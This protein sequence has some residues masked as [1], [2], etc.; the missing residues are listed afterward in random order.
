MKTAETDP[1]W[2]GLAALDA[3]TRL[4]Q[5]LVRA[6]G[7]RAG[8]EAA[9]L[10]QS[11]LTR[12]WDDPSSAEILI[13]RSYWA[14][15][16]SADDT[17]DQIELQGAILLR[18]G[19]VSSIQPEGAPAA[20]LAQALQQRQIS[21]WS[22]L[23]SSMRDSQVL[24]SGLLGI[25]VLGAATLVTLEAVLFSGA[26]SVGARL[27]LL[28]QRLGGALALIILVALLLAFESGIAAAAARLGRRLEIRLRAQ[29]LASMLSLPPGYLGSRPISDLAE[30]LHAAYRIRT[31]P[32]DGFRIIQV[33]AQILITGAAI[34]WLGAPIGLALASAF[35]AIAAPL[36]VWPL[37]FEQD[38]RV[39]THTGAL[40]RFYFETLAG[41]VT[42]RAHASSQAIRR[43]Q[44]SLLVDWVHASRGRLGTVL[45]MDFIQGIT[46][47]GL[48][49]WIMLGQAQGPAPV[50]QFLLL[51]Y[52]TLTLPLLGEELSVLVRRLPNHRSITQRLI[53]PIRSSEPEPSLPAELPPGAIGSPASLE[54]QGVALHFSEVC[55]T[56]GGH[57][58]LEDVSL[59]IAAGEHV[60]ILGVSGAGKSTL[61]G[62]VLGTMEPSGGELRADEQPL[63]GHCLT[64]L[65]AET[66][67]IDPS[68]QLWNR[69]LLDNLLF[70]AAPGADDRVGDAIRDSTLQSV[71]ARLPRGLQDSVGEGG[72][73]L[74]GGEGQK[75]RIARAMLRDGV[76]LAVLDEPF[77]GLDASQRVLLLEQ[78]RSRW[79]G[80]TM[81]VVTHDVS[82]T[83]TFDR[84]LVLADGK[85]VEEGRP[86][87]LRTRA[88]SLYSSM[89][90]D[91]ARAS[92]A[93][94][95][96]T[97]WTRW[98]MERGK[99][100]CE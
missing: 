18:V 71:L 67:W 12:A 80:A 52:W 4:V 98:C 77:R 99:L 26:I 54:A 79:R 95:A 29:F 62:L 93:T 68:V 34:V 32:R 49:I 17:S 70:G 44:E 15:R 82:A 42:V 59:S 23:V 38:M 37:L 78:C 89:L 64:R 40:S 3:G 97:E 43:E 6:R 27:G 57:R 2:F 14:A 74:S 24:R 9:R 48:A 81:L 85:L 94:W 47:F 21:P 41:L 19:G 45:L 46:G 92:E 39:R 31:F 11:Q 73:S 25:A 72:G 1:T 20:S 36:V 66:A 10:L 87:E 91:G 76:R 96:S 30:R 28:E 13:P 50:G 88:G 8:R 100:V 86:A 16:P 65:R 61:L 58:I 33:V 51:A 83:V 60:A 69:S 7:I 63:T 5:A 35:C 53:E 90:L 84:V 55:V 22:V 56:A 75:V